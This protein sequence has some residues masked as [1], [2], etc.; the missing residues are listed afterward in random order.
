MKVIE[1]ATFKL[2]PE[3]TDEQLRVVLADSNR[4]LASQPGFVLRRHGTGEDRRIDYVEWESMADAKAAA[5]RLLNA[6]EAQAFMA[7]IDPTT[8]VMLHFEMIS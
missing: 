2:M 8:V 4:W 7:T 1:L 5:D 3:V 6:P